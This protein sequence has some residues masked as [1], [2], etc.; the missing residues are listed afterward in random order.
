M[1][2]AGRNAST[3]NYAVGEN[4]LIHL[5]IGNIVVDVTVGAAMES[6]AFLVCA[7]MLRRNFIFLFEISV[8]FVC[9]VKLNEMKLI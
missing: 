4:V 9:F 1:G 8:E 2:S 5:S 3:M 6:C 7:I